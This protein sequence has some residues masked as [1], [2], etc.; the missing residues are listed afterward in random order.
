M[1]EK[2]FERKLTT[3]LN[4]KVEG[5]S[6]LMDEDRGSTVRTLTL[7]LNSTSYKSLNP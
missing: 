3:T 6:Q 1:A 5:Y 2:G 4:A 7:Y